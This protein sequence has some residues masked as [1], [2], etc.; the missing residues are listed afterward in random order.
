MMAAAVD[1]GAHSFVAGAETRLFEASPLGLDWSYDVSADGQRFIVNT[2][3][4]DTASTPVTVVVNWTA[5]LK[6]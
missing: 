3:I 4:E 2:R 6:N 5:A 1:G